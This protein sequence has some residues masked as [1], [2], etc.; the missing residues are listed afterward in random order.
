MRGEVDISLMQL[1]LGIA[2]LHC[3]MD[4]KIGHKIPCGIRFGFS[5][6]WA[7]KPDYLL[8]PQKL[9]CHRDFRHFTWRMKTEDRIGAQKMF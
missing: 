1:L 6:K 8:L 7:L 5:G 2:T 4:C 9:C 3:A